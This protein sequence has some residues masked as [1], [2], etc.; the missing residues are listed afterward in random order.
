MDHKIG[1]VQ[2]D[3]DECQQRKQSPCDTCKYHTRGKNPLVGIYDV[4]CFE[5]S[6]YYAS[7]WEQKE[8]S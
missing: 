2:H 8:E 6:H 1:C 5:C 3:C 4:A 7:K